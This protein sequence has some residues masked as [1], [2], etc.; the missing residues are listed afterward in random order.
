MDSALEKCL[1]SVKD[2]QGVQ[3]YPAS[4]LTSGHSAGVIVAL[5]APKLFQ[6]IHVYGL[7]LFLVNSLERKHLK[8]IFHLI[9]EAL[10]CA[11]PIHSICEDRSQ[12]LAHGLIIIFVPK[13]EI[14][15]G[16]IVWAFNYD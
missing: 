7:Y 2:R 11:I 8:I 15:P 13:W 16:Y 5:K 4:E 6:A 14:R 1:T 12:K 10:K 9:S 3:A